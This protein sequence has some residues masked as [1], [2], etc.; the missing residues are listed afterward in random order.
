MSR[1]WI[2]SLSLVL[3]A[4]ACGKKS[5]KTDEPAPG[6]APAPG[7]SATA[8]PAPP[9][10]APDAAPV[11]APPA[12]EDKAI[13]VPFMVETK[14][15][16]VKAR[17]PVAWVRRDALPT[18]DP[19]DARSLPMW[20]RS[21]E[22]TATCD[23]GCTPAEL[24]N[25]PASYLEAIKAH[26]IKPKMSGDPAKDEITVAPVTE[27][28]HGDLPQGGKFALL[29]VEKPVGSKDDYPDLFVGNCITRRPD[30]GFMVVTRVTAAPADEKTWWPVLVEA[31]KATTIDAATPASP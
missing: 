1:I 13:D 31:C 6:G 29:R 15:V 8:T 14:K 30:D 16:K 9:A 19:P 12:I 3:A 22:I 10:P 23:G 11:A 21:Y 2:A 27:L 25:K 18:W 17:V 4:S 26:H 20:H 28:E 24:A 7:G 5:G